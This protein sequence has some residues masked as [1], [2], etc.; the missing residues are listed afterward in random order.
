[1]VR[2]TNKYGSSIV[3]GL[4]LA[5][6]AACSDSA[7]DVDDDLSAS[8]SVDEGG[9]SASAGGRSV[10]AAV[11]P[12]MAQLALNEL[13]SNVDTTITGFSRENPAPR[14]P[15]AGAPSPGPAINV[16]CLA[17]GEANVGGHVSVVPAPVNVDV[18]VAI[19]YNGCVT[20]TGT[21]IQGNIEF[22]QTV[23]A[24]V[25]T[26]LRVET[27]YTGDVTFAGKV[28]ARCPVD[29]NV[30]VDEAGRAVQV[31]GSFCGQD[32]STLDLQISPRWGTAT[33]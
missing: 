21:T 14:E 8:A 6:A 28:N 15:A 30:L 17:G 25:G 9:V 13:A 27:I 7:D 5:L 3:V 11:D 24:G 33:Q 29:L 2:I 20:N 22:S 16:K 4:A 12:A 32:A 31:E 10:S 19:T 18:K 1:M 26:P 23:A